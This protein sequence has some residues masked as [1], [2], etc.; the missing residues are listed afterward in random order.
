[1]KLCI[2]GLIPYIIGFLYNITYY[3]INFLNSIPLL[4]FI[5]GILFHHFYPQ[6]IIINYY[7]TLC[8][9]FF[10]LYMNYYSSIQPY[11]ILHT[12][13]VFFVFYINQNYFNKSNFIHVFCIQLV[14]LQ[15]Y[16]D[17]NLLK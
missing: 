5:N 3:N 16:Y 15:L 17:A 14:S 8:N 2:Y 1:M 11:C 10:Y 9:L 6:N 7:D 12:L 4:I 13:L